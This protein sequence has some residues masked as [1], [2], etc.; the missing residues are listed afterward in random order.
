MRMSRNAAVLTLSLLTDGLLSGSAYAD[1]ILIQ[2]QGIKWKFPD[3]PAVNPL[4][5]EV[6]KGDVLE[7]KVTG[8]HGVV[9]ISAPG[10]QITP[11][12]TPALDPVLPCGQSPGSEPKPLREIECGASSK[13]NVS[14]L[15]GSLKLEVTDAFE[16]DLHFWC[17]VHE[18]DMWGTIKLKP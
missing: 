11:A 9:T 7:F 1:T 5:V 15:T 14:P 8:N 3:K 10:D 18:A 6:K 2:N 13:F 16:K 17:R 12:P 4:L